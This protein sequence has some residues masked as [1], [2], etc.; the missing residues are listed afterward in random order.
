[1]LRRILVVLL[2]VPV[3]ALALPQGKGKG[4]GHN[5]ASDSPASSPG[6]IRFGSP[7]VRVIVDFYHPASGLPPGLAKRGGD[8]PPGLE[9]QLRRNGRLPPGL[10]K[11]L[12][13]FPRDLEARLG[14]IQ[15]GCRR[16][17]LGTWALLIQ[18]ASNVILDIIDL[19]RR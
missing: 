12:M 16:V 7:D 1:M 5:K 11:K 4:K 6:E 14:P 8:L 10:Q 19:S 13:P 17:M 15:P 2:V 3:L 18:D 9:K